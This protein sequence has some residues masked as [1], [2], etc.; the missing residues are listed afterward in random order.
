VPVTSNV[1]TALHQEKRQSSFS[2]QETQ[3]T[4]CVMPSFAPPWKNK[5]EV[6]V[7]PTVAAIHDVSG[8]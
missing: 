1:P 7:R 4:M 2:A 3:A 6:I 8:T 5:D